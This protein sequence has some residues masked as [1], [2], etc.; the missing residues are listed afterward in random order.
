LLTNTNINNTIFNI[1]ILFKRTFFDGNPS[2]SRI[3]EEISMQIK[4][5]LQLEKTFP[6][7]ITIGLFFINIKSLKH[8]LVRKRIDLADLTMKTH[9]SLTTEKIEICCAEYKRMYLRLIEVPTSIE[10]VFEIREWIDTLPL[11]INNQSE[12]VRRL[13]KVGNI[14]L[15]L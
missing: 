11:L 6:E 8:L 9:A 1:I 3:K 13:L 2:L 5:K 10:Q 15:Y 12:I 4:M 7:T 14:I